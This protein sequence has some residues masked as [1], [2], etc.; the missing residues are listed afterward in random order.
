MR[1]L[2]LVVALLLVSGCGGSV[3]THDAAVDD[4]RVYDADVVVY[5]SGTI[6]D[7]HHD[8]DAAVDAQPSGPDTRELIPAAGVVTGGSYRVE[9][10][11]GHWAAQKKISGGSYTSEGAA[12]VKP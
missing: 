8:V 7:A 12:A 3:A 6:W 5:D 4:A 9:V 1:L 11:V 2:I 10:E